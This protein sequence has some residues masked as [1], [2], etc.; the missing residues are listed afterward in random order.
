MTVESVADFSLWPSSIEADTAAAAAA[1]GLL[2]GSS[3]AAQ[4]PNDVSPFS[5]VSGHVSPF[6]R[7]SNQS[8]PLGLDLAGPVGND[9]LFHS[10]DAASTAELLA[11]LQQQQQPAS[12]TDEQCIDAEITRLLQM[13]QALHRQRQQAVVQGQGQHAAAP[14][15]E[16][17][18][19]MVQSHASLALQ[20]AGSESSGRGLTPP[21]SL[22]LD[23]LLPMI[24]QSLPMDCLLSPAPSA[25]LEISPDWTWAGPAA[26][27]APRPAHQPMRHSFDLGP[28]TQRMAAFDIGNG[29]SHSYSTAQPSCA[30]PTAQQQLPMSNFAAQQ[31]MAAAAGALCGAGLAAMPGLP[32]AGAGLA[33]HQLAGMQLAGNQL[34]VQSALYMPAGC[35]S[36]MSLE[37]PAPPHAA[38]RAALGMRSPPVNRIPTG[39]LS[40]DVTSCSS[41]YASSAAPMAAG[42]QQV[43]L[44]G[45]Q[46]AWPSSAAAASANRAVSSINTSQRTSFEVPLSRTPDGH[47]PP[48]ATASAASTG[49]ARNSPTD[50]AGRRPAAFGADDRAGCA[51]AARNGGRQGP[52]HQAPKW[53][54]SHWH[55][56]A[57]VVKSGQIANKGTGVF[58]PGGVRASTAE[59]D[60]DGSAAVSALVSPAH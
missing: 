51:G 34:A 36:R 4:C 42:V 60:V 56:M 55:P 17:E 18:V 35:S 37:E 41:L 2:D 1:V 30:F 31:S 52:V 16:D 40:L 15:L 12:S 47:C 8:P 38:H 33:G 59:L 19:F 46:A 58:I 27:A 26:A 11:L 39:R 22:S 29:C 14:V 48:R 24:E 32:T 50:A 9:Q 45:A 44:H 5:S 23:Q 13:K 21:V 57:D 43:G 53:A 54:G 49:S 7:V 25:A 10:A 3:F 6:S 28:L 20:S